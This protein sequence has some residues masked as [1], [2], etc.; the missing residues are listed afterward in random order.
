MDTQDHLGRGVAMSAGHLTVAMRVE[1]GRLL[2]ASRGDKRK[3]LAAGLS[4]LHTRK[5]LHAKEATELAAIMEMFF[6]APDG[7]DPKLAHRA[8]TYF[9]ALSVDFDSSPAALAI[10]SVI[11]SLTSPSKAAGTGNP[12]AAASRAGDAAFGG[13]GAGCR[14][15]HRV[16]HR[17]PDRRR[18]R[19]RRRRGRR[20][21]YQRG[22]ERRVSNF[23]P[24]FTLVRVG[25]S[26]LHRRLRHLVPR[27]SRAAGSAAALLV[28]LPIPTSLAP[29]HPQPHQPG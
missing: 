1:L 4:E 13:F 10:A 22:L 28:A 25:S 24:E 12:Q 6:A 14:S 27:R 26:R 23:S 21:L 11:S 7:H 2:A 15:R 16:G 17:R 9:Q 19:R 8:S 3:A 18:Y 29:E 20:R 5:I